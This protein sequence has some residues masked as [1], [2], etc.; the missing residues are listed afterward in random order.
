M[1]SLTILEA[2]MIKECKVIMQNSFS[3]VVLFNNSEI[4]IPTN[5]VVDGKAFIKFEDG[6]Y[7]TATKEEYEDFIKAKN[8]KRTAKTKMTENVIGCAA[9]IVIDKESNI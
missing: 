9:D 5:S 4:Q 2:N 1:P 3:S 7:F 6:A 8:E